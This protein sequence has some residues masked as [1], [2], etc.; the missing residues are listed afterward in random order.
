MD[1]TEEIEE[2]LTSL[3][4]GIQKQEGFATTGREVREF[5]S[6]RFSASALDS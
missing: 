6:V 3:I 1:I 2:A 4:C 5:P